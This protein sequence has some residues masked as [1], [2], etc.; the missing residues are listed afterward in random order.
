MKLKEIKEYLNS[1]T[2]E[3]LEQEAQILGDEDILFSGGMLAIS[4][5]YEE[6]WY[7]EDGFFP[8][9]ALSEEQWQEYLEYQGSSAKVVINMGD[10]FFHLTDQP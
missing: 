2:D 10:V 7:S 3:Q 6:Q 4:E 1:L 5:F 8:K 9:S